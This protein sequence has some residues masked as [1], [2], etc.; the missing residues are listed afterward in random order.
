MVLVRGDTARR[1]NYTLGEA[2]LQTRVI[3]GASCLVRQLR[4]GFYL[5][6]NLLRK[7]HS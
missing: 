3:G 5:R 2:R 1:P 6:A 4:D 7:S